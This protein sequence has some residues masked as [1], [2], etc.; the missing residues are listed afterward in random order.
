MNMRD[1]IL[2][3]QEYND[4]HDYEYNFIKKVIFEN[5]EEF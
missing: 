1:L 5:E 3:T 4:H 2:W